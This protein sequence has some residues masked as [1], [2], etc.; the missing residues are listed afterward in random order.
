MELTRPQQ[1]AISY[2]GRNLQLIAC[3]GSGKTEVVARRVA[4]LLTRR[5]RRLGPENIV[6]FTFTNKAAAELKDR[7]VL[8]TEETRGGALV[9]AAEMYV[10]TIHGFCQELLK[11]EVPK[12]LK[13]EPL[14]AVRQKLYVDRNCKKTGLTACTAMNGRKL[15]RHVDTER[16]TAALSALREDEVG[17]RRLRGCTVAKVGM[18]RYREQMDEDGYLDFSAL[19]ELAVREL[20]TN[21]GLRR[22]LA[23]RVKCVVVDEYQD[24]NPIQERLIRHLHDFGADLCVVGDDDQTIYQWRGS[25]VNN[26]V[27]FSERYPNVK[28]LRLQENF[29]SSPGVIDTARKFVETI[30][31][32]LPKAMSSGGSQSYQGGDIV[33]LSFDTPAEEASYIVDTLRSLHGVRFEDRGETRGLAWSDMAVLLRSVRNNGPTIAEALGKAGIPF[34]VVGLANL[35]EAPEAEAARLLFHYMSGLPIGHGEGRRKPP[36]KTVVRKAWRAGGLGTQPRNLTTALNYA[37]GIRE[38][39]EKKDLGL[40]S[41]QAVFLGFLDRIRLRE[42]DVVGS[43]G[44]TALFNLGRFSE[45]ISDW[46]TI[47]FADQT[48]SSFQGFAAFLYYDGSDTYSEGSQDTA[49][50]TPD[51]VQI[52]TVHQAKGREWPVVFLPALLRNRFP[53]PARKSGIW[54]LVPRS[55]FRNA[56]RYDGSEDD[57]RRLFY[58]GMTRSMKFLHLTWAPVPGKQL[59]QRKSVFWEE[60]LASKYVKRRRQN[61]SRRARTTPSPRASVADVEFSFSDLKY[62]FE[63]PYQFKLRVLYGFDAP[64]QRPMGYGKSLHD[65]LAEVHYRAMEGKPVVVDD[66]PELVERHLR[67]PYAFG[68]L[69]EDLKNAAHRDI[70]NYIEDNADKFGQIEFWEQNVE[71][72]LGDGVRIKGRIDLVRRTDT[73]EVTIVDLKSNER[74]QEE[75]VTEH[76]L[77]TYAL[78]Y[79]ELT[80]RDA[81]YVEIYELREGKGKPRP[82]D[83]D[84]MEDVRMRTR[85]AAKALRTLHLKPTPSQRKCS[86]CDLSSLCEASMA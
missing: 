61:Y 38:R 62:M 27:T 39:V 29:R 52:T 6:A 57:E 66:V 63:C 60:I 9:G 14:D 13:H 11:S 23:E 49:Y 8:R 67:T 45:V 2:A 76:Q 85:K 54:Q 26:I 36:T 83:E 74:S 37:D 28:Q 22:R 69:Q 59:Y 47:H 65:A 51:A 12:Y 16:Y 79:E 50:I 32:R 17:V 25:A 48:W 68:K 55:A 80:G 41:V 34:V 71:V 84:F 44:E 31:G 20:D 46:E 35:F 73:E 77:H 3:A 72:N 86:A 78:G 70:Q 18:P 40:P 10:G 21:A 75:Q 19:L 43:R 64:I 5:Q 1:L 42:D 81:D 53:S 33:A 4:H 15:R 58:V 82:V 7:I 24:V 30:D 56:D